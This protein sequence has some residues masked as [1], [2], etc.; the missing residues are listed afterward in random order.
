MLECFTMLLIFLN[1]NLSNL[2]K[3]ARLKKNG[4]ELYILSEESETFD[5]WIIVSNWKPSVERK[6]IGLAY[7]A[8]T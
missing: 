8:L 7:F 6:K 4:S 3:V 2:H 1:W 5:A